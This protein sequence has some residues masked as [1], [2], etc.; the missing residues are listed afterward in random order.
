MLAPGVVLLLRGPRS[1]SAEC[2]SIRAW[3]SGHRIACSGKALSRCHRAENALYPRR[4]NK[5]VVWRKL[6]QCVLSTRAWPVARRCAAR[7]SFTQQL[8]ETTTTAFA[9]RKATAS[10]CQGPAGRPHGLRRFAA[11]IPEHWLLVRS[12]PRGACPAPALFRGGTFRSAHTCVWVPRPCSASSPSFESPVIPPT[13]YFSM[14]ASAP[15]VR[16]RRADDG[17]PDSHNTGAMS[18]GRGAGPHLR[19]HS[20]WPSRRRARRAL[21]QGESRVRL[22]ASSVSS[23]RSRTHAP[24]PPWCS[25]PWCGGAARPNLQRSAQRSAASSTLQ[26]YGA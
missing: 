15:Q 26:H 1:R 16:G 9:F 4:K 22:R 6:S 13:P 2:A 25:P 7:C 18:S 17:H 19:K 24:P 14:P 10:H 5:Y 8:R 3:A 23:A 21:G 20:S 12:G 11:I